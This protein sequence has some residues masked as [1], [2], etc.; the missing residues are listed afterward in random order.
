M[1]NSVSNSWRPIYKIAFVQAALIKNNECRQMRGLYSAD[2][3]TFGKN[4]S[5]TLKNLVT[6]TFECFDCIINESS[7]WGSV[8]IDT[9]LGVLWLCVWYIEAFSKFKENTHWLP[10]KRN[11]HNVPYLNCDYQDRHV[12]LILH[13][14]VNL[15]VR[16]I[17]GIRT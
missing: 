9:F 4:L 14:N 8:G 2:D 16:I 10:W 15:S 13:F 3:V 12:N 6:L 5:L 17:V 1:A 7:T 11:N